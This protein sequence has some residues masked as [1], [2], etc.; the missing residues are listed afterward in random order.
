M[1]EK[2][3]NFAMLKEVESKSAVFDMKELEAMKES[4]EPKLKEEKDREDKVVSH[5]V[6][7]EGLKPNVEVD[8][9]D[10][11]SASKRKNNVVADSEVVDTVKVDIEEEKNYVQDV[12]EEQQASASSKKSENQKPAWLLKLQQLKLRNMDELSKT[13]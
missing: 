11:Q 6:S 10:F 5:N 12:R 7:G 13:D 3:Q 1:G 9:K 2:E 4:N 8:F